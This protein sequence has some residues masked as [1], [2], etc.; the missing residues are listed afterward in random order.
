MQ[1]RGA[2]LGVGIE[3]DVRHAR[4]KLKLGSTPA[5]VGQ[6]GALSVMLGPPP[7]PLQAVSPPCA[8]VP[9][10]ASLAPLSAIAYGETAG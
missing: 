2:P 10:V 8:V 5:L 6:A 4:W 3:G 1:I 9:L 7:V